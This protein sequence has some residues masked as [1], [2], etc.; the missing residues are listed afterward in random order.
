MMMSFHAHFTGKCKCNCTLE[1]LVTS[2]PHCHLRY[3][4]RIHLII[5]SLTGG[6]ERPELE[7]Q[8]P[9]PGLDRP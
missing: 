4:P 5:S 8:R 6:W 3:L 1:L 2:L 9:W 7:L